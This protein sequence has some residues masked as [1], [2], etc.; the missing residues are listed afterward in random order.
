MKTPKG[1]WQ[2]SE[3]GKLLPERIGVTQFSGFPDCCVKIALGSMEGGRRM[4]PGGVQT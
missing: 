1:G 4:D 3:M 2:K